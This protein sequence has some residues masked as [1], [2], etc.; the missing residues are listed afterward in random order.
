[1]SDL[2]SA[3][4]IRAQMQYGTLT[5]ITGGPTHKQLQILEKELA[6][7]LM[8]IP[9]P[10]DH[11]KG[12]L[13][14]LQDPVLYLQRNGASYTVPGA[15][16]PDYPINPTTAAP[17][18]EATWAANLAKRKV[19]NTHIIVCTITHDQFAAAI[20]DV[21][22]AELDDPTK[23]LNTISLHNLI[24]HICSTY[25]IISQPDVA[26]NMA[27]FVAGIK[28]SLPL[29]VYTRK[30][31]KCQKFAQDASVPISEATMVTTGTKAT[32]NCGG[33]EL[34]WC[35][36]KC[37]PLTDHTWNNWKLHWT[38]AFAETRNINCMIANDSAFANQAATDA[39]QA[40]LMAKS[41]DNLANAAIQKNDTVEKLVTANAKLTKAL[42]NANAAIA[43]LRLPN[44]PNPPNPLSTPSRSTTNNRRMSR[45]S[46]IKPD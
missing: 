39:K 42:A 8:A 16:P 45:W 4:S 3:E 37:H 43:R 15:A 12:R 23:G 28:P 11:G 30:Q 38:E 31:V 2:V 44:P 10:W 5:R 41:L 7:N 25:A 19:W 35:K 26:D 18:R 22:Y 27:K 32:L 20:N 21:Y 36:W 33:M 34:A 29:A 13:G 46:A 24:T 14:L 9:C 40:A 1:M 6:A 17:A